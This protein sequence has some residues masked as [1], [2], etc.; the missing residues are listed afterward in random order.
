MLF[1]KRQDF[2][3]VLGKLELSEETHK[4]TL[5]SFLMLPN[6][7]VMRMPMLTDAILNRLRSRD[8]TNGETLE[9]VQNCLDAVQQVMYIRI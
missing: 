7:R 3:E 4:Q 5:Q 9:A 6:Q 1:R 2:C 8:S